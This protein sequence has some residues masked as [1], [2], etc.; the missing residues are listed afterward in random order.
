MKSYCKKDSHCTSLRVRTV[1]PLALSSSFSSSFSF[2]FNLYALLVI[3]LYCTHSQ[4]L[5][6]EE[7]QEIQETPRQRTQMQKTPF[8]AQ[9]QRSNSNTQQHTARRV[10]FAL[11]SLYTLSALLCPPLCICI[12]ICSVSCPT[13]PRARKCKRKRKTD[14]RAAC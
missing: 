7:I 2:S 3:V 11:L 8:R 6:P 12:C 1:Y 5:T 13:P 14:A 9:Q 10:F 4:Y